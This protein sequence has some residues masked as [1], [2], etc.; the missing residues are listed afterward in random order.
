MSSWHV[1]GTG[2]GSGVPGSRFLA[3]GKGS[4][5]G[6][7]HFLAAGRVRGLAGW[8][9]LGAGGGC[10]GAPL[11]FSA[12]GGGLRGRGLAFSGNRA[13]VRARR[14]PFSAEGGGGRG[15]GGGVFWE[16]GGGRGSTAG[17]FWE[18][19][20]GQGSMDP[21]FCQKAEGDRAPGRPVR[22]LCAGLGTEGARSPA[23]HRGR[24]Q[25]GGV[26][27]NGVRGWGRAPDSSP[28][29]LRRCGRPYRRRLAQWALTALKTAGTCLMKAPWK[30]CAPMASLMG[31]IEGSLGL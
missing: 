29:A 12:G 20:R 25:G 2:E 7:W 18:P 21:V 28:A 8:R 13:G 4:G 6:G 31:F 26:S 9:F 10:G 24:T 14:L 1:L 23:A 30:A 11:A 22:R 27:S 17:V 3:P 19:G 5:V 15:W 16:P